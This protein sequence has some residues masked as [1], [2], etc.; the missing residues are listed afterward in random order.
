MKAGYFFLEA[1]NSLGTTYY[2]YYIYFFTENRFGFGKLQNLALAAAV[3][4]SYGIFSAFAGGFAQ[5]RGYFAALKFGLVVLIGALVAGGFTQSLEVQL[6]VLFVGTFGMSF[7]WPSLEALVSEG[8]PRARLQRN[9]GIYNIVWAGAGAIGYFSGGAMIKEWSFHAMFFVPV[10]IL[11]LELAGVLWLERKAQKTPGHTPGSSALPVAENAGH[12]GD[13]RSPVSPSAFLKLAWIANPF[14]Y[15]A[16]NTVVAVVPALAKKFQLSVM[17][18][19]IF[20]SIW[21]FVRTASFVLFW[22]WPAWHYRFRLLAAAY[23]LMT[24]SF[25]TMLL[26][27]NL[28]L[29]VAVQAAFGIAL[30]LIYY[31]SLFYSMDVGETKGAHGGVH[32]AMIGFG[33]GAGP[34]VGAAALYFFPDNPDNSTWATTILLA[35]GFVSLLWLRWRW[36]NRPSVAKTDA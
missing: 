13:G 22:L 7:T 34:A 2:F 27:S 35:A 3:G 14:A 11:G 19:G 33:G 23:I 30:G 36:R 15:L 16:I 12:A 18:A 21:F 29:V 9:V 4:I 5:R 1:L 28:W 10:L 8:E 32:E 20:C 25:A 31:S 17:G 24:A 26:A 6:A